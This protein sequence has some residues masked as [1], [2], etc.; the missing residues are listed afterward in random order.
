MSIGETA[1]IPTAAAISNAVEDAVGARITSLPITAEKVLT[2]MRK[3][4]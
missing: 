4:H 1:L 3:K 2:A